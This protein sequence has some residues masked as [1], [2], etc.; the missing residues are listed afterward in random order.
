[1]TPLTIAVTD[2]RPAPYTAAPAITFRL[3]IEDLE[4]G[5]VHAL[6]LRCQTRI[7]PAGRRYTIEEQTRLCELFGDVSQ[8]DRSLRSVT[9][10]HSSL[11]VPS[12]ERRIEVNLPIPC[13][14]DLEIAS[15][16]YLHAIREGD[17]PLVFLFSG[18]IFKARESGFTAEPVPWDLEASFRMPAALWQTAM[19][20]FF[21]G[22]GWVR[23]RR[24]TIDRL[25]AF[26][27]RHAVVTWDEAIN[28]L[29]DEP[30]PV[31]PVYGE[32]KP[33]GQLRNCI[34]APTALSRGAD[35]KP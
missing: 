16:K 21:P 23:L 26:R 13:T 22:G 14:Y 6:A 17:V 1:M 34:E 35:Q 24:D 12:F 20:Q 7:E 31:S 30:Q 27:G 10:A 9:W 4:G 3:R 2:A 28:I 8:W 29:L 32:D 15:A 19:D 5:G 11:V 18:T 25:Q 33:V